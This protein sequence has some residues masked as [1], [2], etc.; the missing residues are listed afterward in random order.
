[1]TTPTPLGA[2]PNPGCDGLLVET[3]EGIARC[4]WC[5]LTMYMEESDD[6]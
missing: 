6:G 3:I 5:G 2:C 4:S 1:M